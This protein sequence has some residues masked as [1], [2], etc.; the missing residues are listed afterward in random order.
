MKRRARAA[1]LPGITW[2]I[3]LGIHGLLLVL[4]IT[5]MSTKQSAEPTSGKVRVTV[6]PADAPP[7]LAVKLNP[8]KPLKSSL[9]VR[10]PKRPPPQ[11]KPS[12]TPNAQKQA[13][14]PKKQPVQRASSSQASATS[15][16]TKPSPKP[17]PP[18]PG[19]LVVNLGRLPNTKPCRNVGGCWQSDESQWRM[20]Y[21][22]V[23]QQISE[24]GYQVVELELED[25]TGFRVSQILKNGSP[26]YY[27]HLLS[28]LQGTV[29]V[30]NPTQL[31][32]TEVEQK[33]EQLKSTG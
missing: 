25:D 9:P 21:Q 11:L 10:S 14:P 18:E 8:D 32:K 27:L 23:Q 6:L 24:Q 7:K 13:H 2:L 17:S 28:T 29:Y 16:Q 1:Y 4:P 5:S 26:K 15:P 19:D 12:P 33:V 22:N 3:S 30:L 20:V 31:N